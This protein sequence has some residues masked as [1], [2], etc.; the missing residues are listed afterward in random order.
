MVLGK[1]PVPGHPPNLDYRRARGYCACSRCGCG[2]FGR[3][4]SHLSFLFSFSLFLG[5]GPIQTEIL[6]Q[7]AVKAQK[8]PTNLP[9]KENFT[10][11]VFSKLCL[12]ARFCSNLVS[13]EDTCFCTTPISLFWAFN[14]FLISLTWLSKSSTWDLAVSRCCLYFSWFC[15]SSSIT[16]KEN[17]HS[18]IRIFIQFIFY[19]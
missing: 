19:L 14:L 7:R 12:S 1:L 13:N 6:S 3:L 10:L 16:C 15:I 9:T 5:D 17:F 11:Q 4:F 18:T 2:L 8:Q